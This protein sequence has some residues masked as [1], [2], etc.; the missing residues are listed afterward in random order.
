MKKVFEVVRSN[1]Q[2][3][4]RDQ[5]R[6]YSLRRRERKPALVS[7]VLLRQHQLS[8]AA[9]SFAAKLAPKFD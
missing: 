5:G 1:L 9:E 4:S 7:M 6:Y 8:I 2:K 3:T